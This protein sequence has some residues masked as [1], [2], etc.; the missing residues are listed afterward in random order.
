MKNNTYVHDCLFLSFMVFSSLILYVT[1]LGFYSD[2]WAFL[3][4][5]S[6]SQDQSVPGLFASFI[7][8]QNQMRPIQGLYASVLYWFFGPYPLGYHLINAGVF[9]SGC[10]V[11]YLVLRHMQFP[12]I[13]AVAWPLV[14]ALLPHYSTDRFWFA[15]FQA[16]LSMLFYFLSLYAGLQAISTQTK[17]IWA[18]GILSLLSLVISTLSYEVFLPLFLCNTLLFWNPKDM[19]YKSS[20]GQQ[21]PKKRLLFI[22]G[23]FLVLLPVI[24]FKVIETT[25][26]ENG[27]LGNI[28]QYVSYLASLIHAALWVNY[29]V[30]LFQLPFIIGK[31]LFYYF[32]FPVF[33]V[34]ILFGFIIFSY[35]YGIVLSSTAPFP[36]P[37]YMFKMVVWSFVLFI[38][39][40]AIFFTNNNVIFSATGIGNRV[41]IAASLGV[42]LTVL[43]AGGWISRILFTRRFS[44]LFFCIV[45]AFFCWGNFLVINT[46]AL[47]WIVAYPKEMTILRS[48]R[49]QFPTI[50]SNSTI[51]LDGMCPY[52][53]PAI[54]FESSWDLTG[55][56][57]M[58]YSDKTIRADVVKPTLLVEK[59]GIATQIY[60]QRQWYPYETLSVYNVTTNQV[61]QFSTQT[62]AQFYF[63]KISPNFLGNCPASTDGSGVAIF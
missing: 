6:L 55:A 2:D 24:V 30:F 61:Y 54:V 27:P 53:G 49:Q 10:V 26:L 25:R 22:V 5:F 32:N 33:L 52:V 48:I 63:K 18:W 20:L 39:G 45:I 29:G 62:A 38:L 8:P 28:P 16:N 51:L 40:Y 19:F 58:L 4:N 17:K 21:P 56:L 41:A 47:F 31:F 60:D 44:K 11:F 36:N 12:R 46:I 23:T 13:L 35:L 59:E 7:S 9:L 50:P 15:A 1:K 34:S 3:G 57:Y 37:R 43:G 42:A 14:Y